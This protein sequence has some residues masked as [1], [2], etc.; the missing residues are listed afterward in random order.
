MSPHL[1]KSIDD[2]LVSISSGVGPAYLN[3]A[4]DVV[5]AYLALH[6]RDEAE[7]ESQFQKAAMVLDEGFAT[8]FAK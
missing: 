4:A 6:D 1:R 5:R 3:K 8:A 7:F 2:L